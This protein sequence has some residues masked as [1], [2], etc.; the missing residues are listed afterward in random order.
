MKDLAPALP[1]DPADQPANPSRRRIFQ[2]ASAVGLAASL[3]ALADAAPARKTIAK[4]SLDAKLKAHVKNVVVIYLENRSFNNL[5]ANFPGTSAPLSAVTAEQAQ[6]LDRDGKP[7]ATLPKIWGG[8]VPNQQNIGGVDYQIKEDQITGLANAPYKLSDAAGKPLPESIITRDLVHR[9][10]NNQMQINGGKNDGFAA[11]ADSGGLVMG[12]YGET[13]KNLNLWQI[14]EQYTLCDNF[15]MAAFG[16][17][18]M[19]HQ[20]LVTGRANEY[21]NASETAAKKKIAVLADGPQ[22]VRLAIAPDCPASALDGKPKYVNDGAITPDGYAVNTMAPPYQPSYI[23][24]AFDGD[25]LHADPADANTLPPQTYDTIGDLLSRKG[26]SWAWYG[27]GWQAA[28]DHKGGG[29]KPNFQF[30]HQPL[31]YFKQFAPGTAARAEHLRDGGTGDSPISNKFLAAA[32]AGTLP[33]VT[34]YKPQGN[35]NLHAGYSD[36]ES[37]D[38]HVANIIAHLKASPQWKD[39]IVV[40]TFDEN[41]GWWD[42]VAPPKGDRW[43]PGTR[44]PAIVVSPYAKKGAVDHSFYDTTSILRLITRLHDLPLLEGL[45]VRN[46]AFA[47]RGALPPGDLTGA[48]SF[49]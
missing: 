45:K 29:S 35:L 20:F 39:M 31:N 26:V 7:L 40:I 28:L 11:W 24:P 21:F 34:F 16:G 36:I 17:S 33:A 14:A 44:I 25:P 15:F 12:H 41:G 48:L 19:N 1:A 18:Y 43:G 42:H 49:R 32:V 38:Q 23:R 10:Y 13:S 6:Q 47:S 9:F 46:D 5:F 4:G 3:P 2:A 27:G 30:H 8:L 22:G 37:G